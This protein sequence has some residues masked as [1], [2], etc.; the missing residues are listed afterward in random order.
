MR[1]RMY[2]LRDVVAGCLVGPIILER[3]DAPAVRSFYMA[4]EDPK[5]TLS[6]APQDYELLCLGEYDDEVGVT[7]PG[8]SVV[9]TGHDWMKLQ[10][11]KAE[12]APAQS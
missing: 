11:R 10:Q 8:I 1:R 2:Q 6:A 12:D 4:F 7:E 5:S 3:N 9:A